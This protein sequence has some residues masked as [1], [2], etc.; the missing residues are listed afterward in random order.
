MGLSWSD[1]DEF[2]I[3]AQVQ[4]LEHLLNKAQLRERQDHPVLC[5][6][7]DCQ[8]LHG[9]PVVEPGCSVVLSCV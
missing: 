4:P 2:H 8:V 9:A 6:L 5:G 3:Q 7:L 1:E